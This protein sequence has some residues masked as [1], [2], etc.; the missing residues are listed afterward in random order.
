M[1]L[2]MEILAFYPQLLINHFL[3]R[4][5]GSKI[6]H[7]FCIVS[8]SGRESI[9][10]LVWLCFLQ[11]P[12]ATKCFQRF[13]ILWWRTY[14]DSNPERR[15][16]ILDD[17]A[18]K[19]NHCR[20]LHM[21]ISNSTSQMQPSTR[22]FRKSCFGNMRQIYR[23]TPMPKCDFNKVVL[24][25]YENYTLVWVLSC[26]FAAYFQNTNSGGLLLTAAKTLFLDKYRSSHLRCFV[27][28]AVLKNFSIFTGKHLCWSLMSIN[29]RPLDLQLY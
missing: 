20:K 1:Q 21:L 6:A 12:Y 11:Y 5:T 2:R 22:V 26:K 29:Y 27:K 17:S 19:K 3:I 14:V 18:S 28:K 16:S 7:F 8:L 10:L 4:C 9:P 24:Q 25:L 23:R 15:S 13:Q